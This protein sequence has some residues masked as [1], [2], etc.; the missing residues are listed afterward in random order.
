MIIEGKKYKLNK[1]PRNFYS[2]YYY[3][4]ETYMNLP[5]NT[6][7]IGYII[8]DESLDEQTA[9]CKKE[10]PNL[11]YLVY[12]VIGVSSVVLVV[13]LVYFLGTEIKIPTFKFSTVFEG[14]TFIDNGSSTTTKGGKKGLTYKRNIIYVGGMLYTDIFNGKEDC[15]IQLIIGDVVTEAIPIKAKD[16]LSSIEIELPTEKIVNTGKLIYTVGDKIEE[17]AVVIENL[18]V[19]ESQPVNVPA[20]VDIEDTKNTEVT[21]PF[22]NELVLSPKE[23]KI[24]E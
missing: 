12:A 23:D 21:L 24:N 18:D 9:I 20:Y 17:Y 10:L 3:K 1:E 22:Q 14:D 16:T 6:R 7:V 8:M 11:S 4:K 13:L 5:Y 15:T 2:Q 19:E